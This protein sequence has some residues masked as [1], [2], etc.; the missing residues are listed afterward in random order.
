MRESE[1]LFNHTQS[2]IIKYRD[3]EWFVWFWTVALMIG[4][5]ML[6]PLV[7][8]PSPDLFLWILGIHGISHILYIHYR[9]TKVRS[10]YRE[11][12][13]VFP[14]RRK[15]AETPAKYIE[16]WMHLVFWFIVIILIM[17]L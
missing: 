1:L 16:G 11:I 3:R 13:S 8:N 12:E 6:L 17:F 14:F 5:R 9:L 10:T 15:I 2:W 7:L 4:L